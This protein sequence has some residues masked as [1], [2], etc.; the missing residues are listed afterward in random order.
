MIRVV[1]GMI[2]MAFLYG[3]LSQSTVADDEVSSQTLVYEDQKGTT[4]RAIV[5][6][7]PDGVLYWERGL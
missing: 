3:L 7:G 2:V 5:V 6:V 4:G 1:C